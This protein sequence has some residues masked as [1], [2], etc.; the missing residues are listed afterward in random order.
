MPAS[1]DFIEF[2]REQLAPLGTITSRR[3][4]SG[5]SLYLDGTI[6]AYIFDDTLYFKVDAASR[7]MFEVEGSTPF[8]YDSKS[9]PRTING[10][11]RAPDR[12][13]DDPDAMQEF[14]RSALAA[15]HRRA[16]KR[17]PKKRKK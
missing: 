16:A 17:K 8:T 11:W 10:M 15:S 4:F 7:A 9:G 1:A 14:A 6:F 2:L 3:M 5:A 13:F 12:L